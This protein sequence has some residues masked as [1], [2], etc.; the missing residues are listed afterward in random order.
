[1]DSKPTCTDPELGR[2]VFRWAMM[3]S[4]IEPEPS[5]KTLRDHLATCVRCRGALVE[6]KTKAGAG[7]LLIEAER[8]VGG[9]LLPDERVDRRVTSTGTALLAYPKDQPDSGLLITLDR[10][11]RIVSVRAE[12]TR[13][14]FEQA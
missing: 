8:V 12:S 6:W 11:G 5:E 13:S 3:R 2:L 10:Q 1:M 9:R 4:G 14:D 7:R